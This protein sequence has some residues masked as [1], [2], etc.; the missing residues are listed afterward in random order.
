MLL[1]ERKAGEV[2]ITKVLQETV[3]GVDLAG[4]GIRWQAFRQ[5]KTKA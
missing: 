4:E 1:A 2:G 3:L 5:P